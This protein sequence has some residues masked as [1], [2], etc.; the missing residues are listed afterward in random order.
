LIQVQPSSA[1]VT[2]IPTATPSTGGWVSIIHAS[3]TASYEIDQNMV[4]DYASQI[5]DYYGVEISDVLVSTNYET[6]GTLT[7]TIPDDVLES[8]LM[9]SVK[10]NIADSLQIHPQNVDVMIDMENGE[11][12]FT[13]ISETFN[14]ATG[15]AFNLNSFQYQNAISE[16]IEDSIPGLTIGDIEISEDVQI[17]FEMTINANNAVNDLTQAAWQSEQLLSDFDVSIQN[18]YVTQAPTFTPSQSPSTSTPSQIPS[19]TGSVAIVELSLAVSESIHIDDIS[20][21]QKD[22]GD[23]YGVD[24]ENINIEI[25]YQTSG[26]ITINVTDDTISDEELAEAFEAEIATLL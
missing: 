10:N 8:E 1:P 7:L 19:I 23:A 24:A 18:S 6:S 3:A 5:S 26:N 17:E 4:D 25:V 15:I 16:V 12:E 11:V 20:D 21:I 14:E 9:D 22:V 13:I 2:G